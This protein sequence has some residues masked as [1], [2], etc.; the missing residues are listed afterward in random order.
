M[1]SY[2][3]LEGARRAKTVKKFF[4]SSSACVYPEH[5]QLDPNNPGLREGDAW[6]ARPGLLFELISPL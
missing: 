5:N 6:P 2:N 4:Y 3:V 1:I